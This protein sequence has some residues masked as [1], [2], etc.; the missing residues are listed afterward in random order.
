MPDFDRKSFTRELAKEITSVQPMRSVSFKDLIHSLK[1]LGFYAPRCPPI[2]TYLFDLPLINHV[3]PG[4][5]TD[6][7]R[8]TPE[9]YMMELEPKPLEI[10]KGQIFGY[11]EDFYIPKCPVAIIADP[12]RYPHQ[13]PR[14]SAPAY[15]GLMTVDC[16]R[17][18]CS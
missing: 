5:I 16:S 4:K 11:D 7:W 3:V 8:E 13:C 9:L 12:S 2:I 6:V 1:T 14:C 18:S 17:K 15:I 10:P